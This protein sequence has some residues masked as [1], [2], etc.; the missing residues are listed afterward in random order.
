MSVLGDKIF[1]RGECACP[2]WM[3]FL[4]DNWARRILQNPNRILEN[5]VKAG[6]RVLDIGPGRGYF[7]IP[8]A[9]MVGKEGSVVAL[10]IQGKMLELLRARAQKANC[11]NIMTS[12]YDGMTFGLAGSFDFVLMFWMFHEVPGKSNFIDEIVSVSNG[13]TRVL[14]VEPK[15]HVTGKAFEESVELFKNK[16]L[17]ETRRVKINFSRAAELRVK[18][19]NKAFAL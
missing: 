13:G 18:S 6:G 16:G 5:Y 1:F 11:G 3:C 14:L 8:M 7:T 19:S 10:D 2:W 15:I 9:K 4:F 12:L 17:E